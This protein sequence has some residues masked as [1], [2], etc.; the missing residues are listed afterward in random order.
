MA[1]VRQE[2]SP[3]LHLGGY[4]FPKNPLTLTLR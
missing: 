3:H 2:S 1:L 4:E